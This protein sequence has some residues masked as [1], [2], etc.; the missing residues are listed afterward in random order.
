MYRS[1]LCLIKSSRVAMTLTWL[2]TEHYINNSIRWTN[3]FLVDFSMY[4][5]SGID[6]EYGITTNFPD[7]NINYLPW[8][9][10]GR[11]KAV[12]RRIELQWNDLYADSSNLLMQK[13]LSALLI[14]KTSAS[15]NIRE[16]NSELRYAIVVLQAEN[17]CF[18]SAQIAND[19]SYVFISIRKE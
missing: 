10:V 3:I 7:E 12:S 13:N 18:S 4:L 15:E 2:A 1:N 14:N 19:C 16:D 6:N 9:L 5:S 17:N 8:K 11:T